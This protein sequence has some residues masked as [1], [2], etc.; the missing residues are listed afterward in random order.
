MVMRQVLKLH[1]GQE[2][3]GSKLYFGKLKD[4]QFSKIR[5]LLNKN[6]FLL[7][8]LIH[9][10]VLFLYFSSAEYISTRKYHPRHSNGTFVDMVVTCSYFFQEHH[11]QR[12]LSAQQVYGTAEALVIPVPDVAEV[13]KDRFNKLYAPESSFKPPKQYVHVQ[14][15]ALGVPQLL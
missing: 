13:P 9:V 6:N 5:L 7:L 14:G 8:E 12:A 3:S 11:L 4:I 10:V 1:V 2:P 15:M